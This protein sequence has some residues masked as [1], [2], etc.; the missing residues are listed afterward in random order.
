MAGAPMSAKFLADSIL[1]D[2]LD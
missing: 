1:A 2:V